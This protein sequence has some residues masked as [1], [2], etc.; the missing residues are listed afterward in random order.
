MDDLGSD[1]F[2]MRTVQ[3]LFSSDLV[4]NFWSSLACFQVLIESCDVTDLKSSAITIAVCTASLQ[5][6]IEN[7][8]QSSRLQTEIDSFR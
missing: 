5:N 8:Q 6:M 4:E 3:V 1:L 7:F 2:C